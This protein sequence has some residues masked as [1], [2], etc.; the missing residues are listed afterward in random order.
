MNAR[1]PRILTAVK[2]LQGLGVELLGE[3]DL[4]VSESAYADMFSSYNGKTDAGGAGWYIYTVVDGMWIGTI[5]RNP[6]QYIALE[7]SNHD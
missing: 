3:K 2:L 6:E 7:E 1:L 5:T 4:T